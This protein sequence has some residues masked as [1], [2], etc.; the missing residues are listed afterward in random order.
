VRPWPS[1]E[2]APAQPQGAGAAVQHELFA[3]EAKGLD[4]LLPPPYIYAEAEK[5]VY[6]VIA[7][8][9]GGKAAAD[10]SPFVHQN[11][12]DPGTILFLSSRHIWG[13]SISMGQR[14]LHL[15]QLRHE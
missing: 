2:N 12:Y 4:R 11:A 5:G 6:Q 8:R 15:P 3:C 10:E 7:S 14:T 9:D 1:A 13:A